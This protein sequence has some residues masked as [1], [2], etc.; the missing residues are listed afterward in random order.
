MR[1]AP[2]KYE[3]ERIFESMPSLLDTRIEIESQICNVR[4]RFN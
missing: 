2:D 3:C 1:N 4:L